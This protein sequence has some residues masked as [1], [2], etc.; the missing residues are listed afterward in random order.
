MTILWYCTLFFFILLSST[1]AHANV[2]RFHLIGLSEDG[3]FMAFEVYRVEE[4]TGHPHALIT[5]VNTEKN[6]YAAPP[7]VVQGNEAVP[8]KN[9]VAAIRR[10]AL[11]QAASVLQSFHIKPGYT[12]IS[13]RPAS[14]SRTAYRLST[15]GLAKGLPGRHV[16]LT[17]REV[18]MKAEQSICENNTKGLELSL[19]TKDVK[20]ETSKTVLQRDAK[21][22]QS[23]G[24]PVSYTIA[25]VVFSE[26]GHVIVV[27]SYENGVP[28]G[29]HLEYM[30][31]TGQ[32]K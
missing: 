20:G 11:Q 15:F 19:S 25:D 5:L 30:V 21:I 8:G 28:G 10:S 3:K 24:C 2:G 18:P 17:L 27:L 12:G 1:T 31:V 26:H 16:E 6:S 9:T 29:P 14:H 32:V 22:A 7:I 23:R 4:A 13:A